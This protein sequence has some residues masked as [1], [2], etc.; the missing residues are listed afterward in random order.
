MYG[1]IQKIIGK[2]IID[3]MQYNALLIAICKSTHTTHNT[4]NVVVDGIDVKAER[5]TIEG[6]LI[7]TTRR[8]NTQ[9][10]AARTVSKLE[11]SVVNAGK[12][13]SA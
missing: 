8:I 12:V 2:N 5:T 13:A 6:G 1:N 7:S 9:N 3:I 4:E 11:N 10:T